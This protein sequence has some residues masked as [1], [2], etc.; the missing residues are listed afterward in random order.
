MR[1]TSSA[2]H[3][4]D[5]GCCRD[6]A[7]E[8]REIVAT[9]RKIVEQR[10]VDC[11]LR[12]EFESVFNLKESLAAF[13]AV[14]AVTFKRTPRPRPMLSEFS[15]MSS[16]P[17]CSSAATSFIREST[18]PRTTPSL[19][20]MR[21]TV[22]RDRPERPAGHV[23]LINPEERSR[24]FHLRSSYHSRPRQ[25]ASVPITSNLTYPYKYVKYYN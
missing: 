12:Q 16:I 23:P 8:I 4:R 6:K 10:D 24:R 15:P 18:F 7:G 1:G 21:C 11:I 5:R 9:R 19:A 22:G 17:A 14:Q 13:R 20:S 25:I 2:R 3:D